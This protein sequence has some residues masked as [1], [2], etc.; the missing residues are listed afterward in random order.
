MYNS[1]GFSFPESYATIITLYFLG[2][3]HYPKKKP[4]PI[5]N[6]SPSVFI[7]IW[8]TNRKLEEIVQEKIIHGNQELKMYP[9]M[10][11]GCRFL[12]WAGLGQALIFQILSVFL[13]LHANI[14]C[15]QGGERQFGPWTSKSVRQ[16]VVAKFYISFYIIYFP[17]RKRPWILILPVKNFITYLQNDGQKFENCK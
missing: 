8:L 5:N 15:C 7:Y 13:K 16:W 10:V 12:W 3:F 11:W 4:V 17:K 6:H 1:V 14:S 9:N 2:P